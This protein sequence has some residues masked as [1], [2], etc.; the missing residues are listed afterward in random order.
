MSIDL[1]EM[2]PVY[3]KAVVTLLG[4]TMEIPDKYAKNQVKLRKISH[5]LTETCIKK[6]IPSGVAVTRTLPSWSLAAL[7]KRLF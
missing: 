3:H 2:T 1:N 4:Q 7:A 6:I 5:K